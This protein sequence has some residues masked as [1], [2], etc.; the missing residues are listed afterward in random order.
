MR[1][2]STP[3]VLPKQ[4]PTRGS[5]QGPLTQRHV[6]TTA[7]CRSRNS[8][9][10][11][12]SV[13]VSEVHRSTAEDR[14]KTTWHPGL[15]TDSPV[16]PPKFIYLFF[17]L[18]PCTHFLSFLFFVCFFFPIGLRL[19]CVCVVIDTTCNIYVVVFLGWQVVWP[20]FPGASNETYAPVWTWHIVD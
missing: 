4:E 8:P 10:V 17:F 13:G 11:R 15:V 5:A 18:A 16:D 20:I 9:V 1:P 12:A 6:T 19:L 7:S 14:R 3:H 2:S